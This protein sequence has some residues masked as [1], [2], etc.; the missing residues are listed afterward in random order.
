MLKLETKTL[1]SDRLTLRKFTID[2]AQGMF[3]NWASDPECCKFSFW[4]IHNNV[5]ETNE[6]I[7]LF[8]R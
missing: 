1:V 3:Y 2:D 8:I 6:M 4:N 7:Q 5:E